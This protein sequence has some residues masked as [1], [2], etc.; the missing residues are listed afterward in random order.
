MTNWLR[1]KLPVVLVTS[2]WT[3]VAALLIAYC[4]R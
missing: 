1:F 4:A 2:L 3:G